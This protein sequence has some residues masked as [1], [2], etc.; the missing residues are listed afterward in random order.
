MDS[1]SIDML[2]HDKLYSNYRKRLKLRYVGELMVNVTIMTI[3]CVIVF[4]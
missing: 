3:G 4:T 1:V 2:L